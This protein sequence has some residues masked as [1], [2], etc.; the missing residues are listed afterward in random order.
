LN[1]YVIFLKNLAETLKSFGKVVDEL[2]EKVNEFAELQKKTKPEKEV[3]PEPAPKLEAKPAEKKAEPK[4]VEEAPPK[5]KAVSATETVLNLI[6][7]SRK[8]VS[9]STIKDKTGFDSRKVNSIVYRL[10]KRGKI[11]SVKKGVYTKS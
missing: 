2:G 11:K 9:I 4:A 5:E 7:K 6:Q 3:K 1:E 10:K 8:G